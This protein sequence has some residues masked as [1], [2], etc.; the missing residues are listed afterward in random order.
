MA[1]R[2]FTVT[3]KMTNEVVKLTTETA[4]RK[5]IAEN[6]TQTVPRFHA[7]LFER[8]ARTQFPFQNATF[9]I[10]QSNAVGE[11]KRF[12]LPGKDIP[13]NAKTEISDRKKINEWIVFNEVTGK[14]AAFTNLAA[15]ARAL[16]VAY[17]YLYQ[18]VRFAH[19]FAF[20]GIVITH[21]TKSE[22]MYYY[23]KLSEI[24]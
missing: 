7:Y 24:M 16:N 8:I 23:E 15:L 6:F 2:T 21:S 14:Y 13:K 12:K 19:S 18:R 5:F 3:N 11:P 1:P 22:S 20:S 17:T 9:L 4:L 10:E